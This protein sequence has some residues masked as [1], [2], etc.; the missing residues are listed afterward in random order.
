MEQLFASMSSLSGVTSATT[1]PILPSKF[2]IIRI[3]SWQ[4]SVNLAENLY[5]SFS[6]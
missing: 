2:E 1:P 6:D 3:K 5:E 4:I